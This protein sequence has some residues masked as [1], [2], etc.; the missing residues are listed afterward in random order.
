[1]PAALVV[2]LVALV[3][4]P[5]PPYRPPVPGPVVEAFRPP[6]CTWCPGNRGIDYAPEPGTP[7]VASAAGVVTV[8]GPV[9]GTLLVVVA[10]ADGL[11]TTYHDLATVSVG[12]GAHVDQGTL[13]GLSGSHLHFGVRRGARYLDPAALLAA[14]GERPRLV[15][16]A[17]PPAG[18]PD[19]RPRHPSR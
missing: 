11:R 14:P 8:A 7:V 16:V 17:R 9:G 3:F 2:V 18:A 15:P 6:A 13:L 12:V 1:M 19:G 10:H 5:A 4:A